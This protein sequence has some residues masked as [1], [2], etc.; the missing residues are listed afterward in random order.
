MQETF[1]Q[2]HLTIA[3]MTDAAIGTAHRLPD[4]G[5]AWQLSGVFCKDREH[6]LAKEYGQV[7]GLVTELLKRLSDL[8]GEECVSRKSIRRFWMQVLR[9]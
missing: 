9:S 1:R 3:G 6:R 5:E 2:E 8:L 7:Y 4:R